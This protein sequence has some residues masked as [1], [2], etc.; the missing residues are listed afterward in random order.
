M[1]ETINE[2]LR[3]NFYHD[4]V[5]KNMIPGFETKVLNDE[6]SSFIA[7]YKLLNTYYDQVKKVNRSLK[8]DENRTNSSFN[9]I[10]LMLIEITFWAQFN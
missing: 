1:Y 9:G 4:N 2:Q 10:E 8:N 5:I 6:M 3:D 7:A